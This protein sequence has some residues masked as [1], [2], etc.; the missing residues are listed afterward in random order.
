[1]N[2]PHGIPATKPE[3]MLRS[4]EWTGR[5]FSSPSDLPLSFV[6]GERAIA[7]IPEDWQPVSHRR[8]I[9]ANIFETVF[10]GHDAGTGLNVQ[11]ACRAVGGWF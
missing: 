1:M 9:D 7:G 4:R 8:R 3:D 6:L 11:V 2:T 10:E 5:F